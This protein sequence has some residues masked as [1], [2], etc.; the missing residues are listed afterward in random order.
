LEEQFNV[1]KDQ[2]SGISLINY[3]IVY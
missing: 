1:Y 2:H 3:M